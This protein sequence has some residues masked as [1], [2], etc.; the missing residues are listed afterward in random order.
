MAGRRRALQEGR[1]SVASDG[2]DMP[3][4]D[5]RELSPQFVEAVSQAD[6]IIIDGMGRGIETNLN[7]QFT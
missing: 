2:S 5:L 3:V 1:V 6:L 4:I 7:A